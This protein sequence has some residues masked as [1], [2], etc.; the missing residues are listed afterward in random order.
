MPALMPVAAP[1]KAAVGVH[2]RETTNWHAE[3]L[4]FLNALKASGIAA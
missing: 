1:L 3:M 2:Q 4:A